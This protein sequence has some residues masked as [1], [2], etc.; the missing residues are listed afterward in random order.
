MSSSCIS[1]TVLRHQW[2]NSTMVTGKIGFSVC[3]EGCGEKTQKSLP[4]ELAWCLCPQFIVVTL[5]D[6]CSLDCITCDHICFSVPPLGLCKLHLMQLSAKFGS[7]MRADL[8]WASFCLM[9]LG[10]FCILLFLGR[11]NIPAF[12][13]IQDYLPVFLLPSPPLPTFLFSFCLCCYFFLCFPLS[14]PIDG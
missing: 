6:T 3:T 8:S 9:L 7:S 10:S 11:G 5:E 14:L 13:A 1:T 2:W 12:G 4:L